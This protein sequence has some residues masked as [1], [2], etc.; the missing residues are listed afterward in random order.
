MSQKVYILLEHSY[1]KGCL[2]YRKECKNRPHTSLDSSG[3][4]I[5]PSESHSVCGIPTQLTLHFIH[6]ISIAHFR[7]KYKDEIGG[8]LQICFGVTFGVR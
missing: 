5:M 3:H 4:F 8:T 6:K 7:I 2:K 1:L